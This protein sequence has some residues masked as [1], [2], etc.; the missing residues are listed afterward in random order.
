MKMP[1]ATATEMELDIVGSSSFGRFSKI[2]A[3]KT[4]NMIIADNWMVPYPG[5]AQIANINNTAQGRAIYATEKTNVLIAV[6]GNG[7]YIVDPSETI[8]TKPSISRIGSLATYNGD[9]FI[10]ENNNSQVAITDGRNIY[11]Y[12]YSSGT[13][14]TAVIDFLPG[15]ISFQDGYFISVDS[16]SNKWRL[17]ESNNGLVWPF[18]TI[19]GAFT[20]Q[21]QT[22]P[23]FARAAIRVPG[24]GNSLLVF[25]TN[26]TEQWVDVGATPFPYQKN[27]YFNIDYGC[28][29]PSSIAATE[30]M[31]IWLGENEKSGPVILYTDG[32][33]VKQI[34]TDGINYQI[35]QLT[36]VSNCYAFIT[37]QEGHVIYQI[38]W[39][40]D[41]LSL[42][43]D[44]NT[45]KFFHVTN[46]TQGAHIAKRIAYLNGTYYFVSF[47]DGNIYEL[48]A[49]YSNLDG[50]EMPQ[51]RVCK[52]FR[53][54]DTRPFVI[55]WMGFVMEQG[56]VREYEDGAQG[57]EAID[58]N[59][60]VDGGESFGNAQRF[61][62]NRQGVRKN[63]IEF[64]RLGYV[65]DFIP[66]FRFWGS[67]RFICSNGTVR[68]HR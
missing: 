50:S 21:I 38:T 39:P 55:S 36:N 6:V 23:T 49:K 41:N 2:S 45:N 37:N 17:S 58:M 26:I 29:N 22:K 15:Y 66:Q 18:V 9:V 43:Y 68:L 32:G 51:I 31:V 57:I 8:D 4:V 1:F 10:A 54:P 64:P 30:N 27:T 53:M 12:N 33:P 34:S 35:S 65:N 28:V 60:S 59:I 40:D 5:Y 7:V 20:S 56:Q 48:N 44:F 3:Q 42:I 19:S 13:F 24:A 16:K 14:Q 52:N 46:E 63:K 47:V 11:V 61:Q 25:G 62:L 67:G